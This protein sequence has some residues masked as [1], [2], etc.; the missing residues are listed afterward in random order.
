MLG[1]LLVA[2]LA[3]LPYCYDA[4]N[5]SG[6]RECRSETVGSYT[7]ETCYLPRE[8]GV[9]CRLYDARS[10]EMLAERTY[11][12]PDVPRLLW[13]D[14]RVRYDFNAKDG[15]GFVKLPPTWWDGQRARLP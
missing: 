2:M 9:V 12:D 15:E 7:G 14:D 6:A 10:G 11:L 5:R 8:W 4:L 1:T 3:S 13:I